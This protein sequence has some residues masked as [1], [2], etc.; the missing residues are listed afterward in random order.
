MDSLKL[1]GAFVSGSVMML[2]VLAVWLQCRLIP[3]QVQYENKL[4]ECQSELTLVMTRSMNV[5]L[6]K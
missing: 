2:F 1:F 4:V 6:R 5:S 3:Q